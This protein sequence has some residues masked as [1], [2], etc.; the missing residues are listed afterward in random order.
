MRAIC[1]A[2]LA[3]IFLEMTKLKTSGAVVTENDIKWACKFICLELI[4][5]IAAVVL[6][7]LGL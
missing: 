5:V 2:I 6:C 4:F 7:I 3:L 1:C